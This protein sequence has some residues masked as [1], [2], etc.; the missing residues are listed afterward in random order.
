M[1]NLREL[2]PAFFTGADGKPLSP[3]EI[4]R[5]RQVAESLLAQATDTSPNAGGTASVLAKAIQ[6]LSFGINEGRMDRAAAANAERSAERIRAMLGGGEAVGGMGVGLGAGSVNP[7]NTTSMATIPA[8]DTASA[9]VA[10]G[11]GGGILPPTFQSILDKTEGGGDYDTLFGHSQ[12][13]GPFAGTSVSSMTIAD[14][15]AFSDPS[16]PYA[17]W[18]KQR[19]GRVA[20]PMGRHQIV[21]TTLRNAVKELGLDPSKPFDA[22]TQDMI[23]LHLAKRRVQS[24]DTLD[25]KINALRSEWEGFKNVPREQLAQVVQEIESAPAGGMMPEPSVASGMTDEDVAASFLRM[26]PG[27]SAAPVSPVERAPLEPIV[28][29]VAV[30]ETPEEILAAEA[31]MAGDPAFAGTGRGDRVGAGVQPGAAVTPEYTEQLRERFAAENAGSVVPAA[32]PGAVVGPDSL[33]LERERLNAAMAL[34]NM[35]AEAAPGPVLD[36]VAAALVE[37]AAAA[38]AVAA[39]QAA[40]PAAAPAVD[41]VAAALTGYNVDPDVP[42]MGVRANTQGFAP[43]QAPAAA[44]PTGQMAMSGGMTGL[45]PAVIE[46]LADPNASPEERQIAAMLYEQHMKNQDPLRQL[47]IAEAQRKMSQR[48]LIN[49]GGGYLYDQDTGEWLQAPAAPGGGEGPAAYE[50]LRRRAIAGGL[51]E[52]TPEFQQFMLQGGRDPEQTAANQK[53]QQLTAS[54]LA[55]GT[56]TDPAQAELAAKGI[57]YGRYEFMKDPVTQELVVVD[58]ATLRPVFGGGAQQQPQPAPEQ[59]SQLTNP[60]P[61]NPAGMYPNATDAFGVQGA[62]SGAINTV[63]DAV[64]AGPVYPDVA[65]AQSEFKVLRERLLSDVADSYGR[66]PPSWLLKRIDELTPAAGSPMEGPASAQNKLRAIRNS[67]E[68]E[69]AVAQ[70]Q[71]SGQVSPTRRQELE[72][73]I[74]GLEAANARIDIAL[75]AFKGGQQQQTQGSDQGAQAPAKRMR[76]NPKTGRVE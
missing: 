55:D 61:M 68:N 62:V 11:H 18:V 66:Q 17:Q 4:K 45:P 72:A 58:K 67:F 44:A 47:Q 54:F 33:K 75:D 1:A 19:V 43:V 14:A 36:P 2:I 28:P 6:G 53:V 30:A 42:M 25:G 64:G 41:P 51:Q 26:N 34:P 57:A 49:V 40:T 21:G 46:A 65:Q 20:T 69:I 73:R 32:Q 56:F 5:R 63:S 60:E 48:N 3:E 15:L 31:A 24:A 7:G 23:A 16:G 22:Q 8:P 27:T 50:A 10:Q 39:T 74:S 70:R 52:G 59:T 71:L 9:R 35:G 13:D 38:P 37:P 76:Y 29:P 12:K